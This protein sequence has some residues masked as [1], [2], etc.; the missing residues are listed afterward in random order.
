MNF[1]SLILAVR[2]ISTEFARR[3]YLPVV[4]I[5]EAIL[6]VLIGALIW[7][8]TISGWWWL[9]LA[10]TLLI[11]IVFTVAATLIGLLINFLK[12][13]QTKAQRKEVRAFVDSLQHTTETVQTPKFIILFRLAKDALAP[14][15]RSFI[16]EL[17]YQ[18]RSL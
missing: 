2:T 5:I 7:L 17:S 15:E 13:A 12:P 10:P 18:S 11:A 16:R 14:S 4:V 9:L 8:V 3:I 1:N 6:I